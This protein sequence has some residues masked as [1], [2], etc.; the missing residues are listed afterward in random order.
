MM[1]NYE[2]LEGHRKSSLVYRYE[3]HCFSKDKDQNGVRYLKCVKYKDGCPARAKLHLELNEFSVIKEHEN[4]LST[5]RDIEILKVKSKLKRKSEYSQG[6]LRET[7]DNKVNQSE[8]GGYISF[9]QIESTMY[10]RKRL[11]TSQVPLNAENAISLME[12]SND[13]YKMYHSFSIY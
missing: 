12:D 6:T 1:E 11:H 9:A 10:K 7:F 4:H 5:E 8:V 2:T 13:E 3:T